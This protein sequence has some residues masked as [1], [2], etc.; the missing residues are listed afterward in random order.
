MTPKKSHE[1]CRQQS[2]CCCGARAGPF[3]VTKKIEERIKKYAKPDW[4]PNVI[5]YP[6]GLCGKC[7][8]R[9]AE[10]EKE[11]STEIARKPK[12]WD[13]FKLQKIHVPRGQ[14]AHTC[15]CDMCKARKACVGQPG[16]SPFQLKNRKVEPSGDDTETEK[17][18]K[19]APLNRCDKCLQIIGKG[20]GHPCS[21]T[22][23]KKNLIELV[24]EQGADATEQ[25]TAALVKKVSEAK[26]LKPE[27]EIGLEQLKGG[28]KLTI[29]VA[30]KSNSQYKK[31]EVQVKAV[32]IGKIKKDL[33]LSDR[34]TEKVSRILRS[35]NVKVEPNTRKFLSDVDQHLAEEYETVTMEMEVLKEIEVKGK[36]KKNKGKVTRKKKIVVK[37]MKDVAIV[38]DATKFLNMV[39][40]ERGLSPETAVTRVVPDG[41]GGSFKVVASTYDS[42]HNSDGPGELNTGVNRLLPLAVAESCPE[43]H[44]N[45]RQILDHLKLHNV[46]GLFIVGDLKIYNVMLGISAHGGKHACAFCL[47]ISS[48][49]SGVHRTF[50]HLQDHHAAYIEAGANPKEMQNFYNTINECLLVADRDVRVLDYLILP[51]LHMMMGAV[52]H[53]VDVMIKVWPD[54]LNWMKRNDVV[55]HGYNGGGLD[56]RNSNKLLLKLDKLQPELPNKLQPVLR[57][58]R[59]FHRI[60]QGCFSHD[61]C[62]DYRERI[63]AFKT[64]YQKLQSYSQKTLK[65][66]LT[67]TWKV[68]CVTAHL[69]DVLTKLGKGLADMAEQTGEAAHFKMAP[70]MA[71]HHRQ[72]SHRDH[73][74]GQLTATIKFASWNLKD[75]KQLKKG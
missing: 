74:K 49:E 64:S 50:G 33:N 52:G 34:Q 1:Q 12:A 8:V 32:T 41:G 54:I 59:L 36:Q 42:D 3:Q 14:L 15:A 38:K 40:K 56:G 35:D 48:L 30:S 26:N 39:I 45:I 19:L 9:L 58:L 46:Q 24:T 68:H 20:I 71:R 63:R 37:E 6:T 61:L 57:T 5:S 75:I 44:F 60:V 72:E 23:R 27:E 7:R 66:R 2:C 25:V 62:S 4:D 51:E 55:R 67:V 53:L 73:G 13:T 31:K 10:C 70:V 17:Q 69:E 29:K 47:G 65:V 11:G 28:S 18:I 22:N 43:R 21:L 16:T